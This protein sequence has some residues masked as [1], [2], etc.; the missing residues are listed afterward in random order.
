MGMNAKEVSEILY[1]MGIRPVANAYGFQI[2]D[3][4]L[5]YPSEAVRLQCGSG[6]AERGHIWS[7]VKVCSGERIGEA[8]STKKQLRKVLREFMAGPKPINPGR[9]YA[10]GTNRGYIWVIRNWN[11]A[12]T[13]ESVRFSAT[14]T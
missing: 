12:T 14:E 5:V 2:D 1:A 4:A 6:I 7:L 10:K 3:P 8:C 9:W 11:E 13:K